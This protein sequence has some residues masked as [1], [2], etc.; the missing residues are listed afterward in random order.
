MVD[1]ANDVLTR[2]IGDGAND[3]MTDHIRERIRPHQASFNFRPC[4]MD[5]HVPLRRGNRRCDYDKECQVLRFVLARATQGDPESVIMC[6]LS[7]VLAPPVLLVSLVPSRAS[8]QIAAP[9]LQ[10]CCL[11]E[12]R[13]AHACN[14]V[15][16]RW[17]SIACDSGQN[18]GL[19]LSKMCACTIPIYLADSRMAQLFNAPCSSA[20]QKSRGIRVRV[21]AGAYVALGFNTARRTF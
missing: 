6:V 3:D 10:F 14:C 8:L 16:C 19:F 17:K 7:V 18:F 13:R 15:C 1:S 20:C 2:I 12:R 9:F 11:T 5:W 4:F 21:C